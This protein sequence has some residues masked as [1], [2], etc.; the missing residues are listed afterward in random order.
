MREDCDQIEGFGPF[1]LSSAANR[2][3]KGNVAP[4]LKR[5]KRETALAL[6]LRTS[7]QQSRPGI[8]QSQG[9]R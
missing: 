1:G 9:K 2:Q 8:F 6:A 5:L 4:V 3:L 7:G